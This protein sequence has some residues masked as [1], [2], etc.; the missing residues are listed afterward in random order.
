M[1]VYKESRKGIGCPGVEAT[2]CCALH[3]LGSRITTLGLFR[4]SK[5]LKLL[6]YLSRSPKCLLMVMFIPKD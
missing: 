4:S 6:K 2:D 5:F 1:G 3:E